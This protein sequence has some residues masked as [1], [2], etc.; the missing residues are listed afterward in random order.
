MFTT[1]LQRDTL[2]IGGNVGLLSIG[3]LPAG[4]Q[5]DSLTWVPVRAYTPQEGGLPPSPEA[6][7]EVSVP[8]GERNRSK[9]FTTNLGVS[10]NMGNTH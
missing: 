3:E 7:K 2:D 1:T 6:P 4:I 5:S 10:S 9:A 8:L